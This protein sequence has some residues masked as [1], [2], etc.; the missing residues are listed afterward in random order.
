M[1]IRDICFAYFGWFGEKLS[2]LLKG[3]EHDLDAAYMKVHPDVYFSYVGFAAFL[4]AVVLVILSI[5]GFTGIFPIFDLIPMSGV[6]YFPI[7]VL[8]PVIVIVIG[9]FIPKTAA[10]NRMAGL[11]I[12][13]PYASMYISTMTSGGLSPF[14]SILRLGNMDLLPNMQ[15]EVSRI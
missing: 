5:M 2:G 9:V 12:E 1:N 4:T 15:D 8:V 14:E 6:M 7:M 13:I 3:T 10:S 11:Q